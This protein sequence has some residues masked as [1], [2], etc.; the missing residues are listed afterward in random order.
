MKKKIY[1]VIALSFAIMMSACGGKKAA[2]PSSV[3]KEETEKAT[4][5]E[6]EKET[7]EETEKEEAFNENEFTVPGYALGEI[8]AIPAVEINGLG[9]FENPAAKIT[10]DKTSILSSV[11]GI[12]VTP[13]KLENDQ[14]F[15][16][17]SVMQLGEGGAGQMSADGL[18]VQTDGNG[19]G[20]YVDAER[21]IT[22][23][24]NTDGSGQYV[25]E[26]KGI[27]LQVNSDGTGQYSD[28]G[29]GITLQVSGDGNGI[30]TDEKKGITMMVN[31]YSTSY[32]Q[33]D[34][35]IDVKPDGSGSYYN[36][37]TD[38][39][40]KN[41]GQGKADIN[42]G[43]QEKTV[44]AKPLDKPT[45]LPKLYMVPA[46]PSLEANSLL[47][48]LD[49]GVLF[50]VDKYNIRP[51]AEKILNDLAKVLK[52][53]EITAFQIDGHTDSDASDEHNQTLSENRANSV[54][55]YL[56]SQGVNAEITTHGYGE[57]RPVATNETAEGKQQ[58]RRVE[59]IIPT[60]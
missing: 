50:D 46:V 49:S 14:I 35:D 21:G 19:A 25:D 52:E 42:I 22:I 56:A 10:M 43:Y 33:G 53:A 55:N 7:E 18:T 15:R 6:T 40:I 4:R 47:I 58:N 38:L 20:Q 48:T 23:Q 27:T 17:N 44:D 37:K 24:R 41:D 1:P 31:D 32:T 36:S 26:Q 11:P 16:G 12:T 30:F 3:E 51:D 57:S 8:P 60:I 13:V 2:E 59:I 28:E 29:Q 39:S 9:I 45:K 54:K 5:E 34:I